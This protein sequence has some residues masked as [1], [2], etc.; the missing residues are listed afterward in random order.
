MTNFNYPQKINIHGEEWE[1]VKN[2]NDP[3][4]S[5]PFDRVNTI[6]FDCSEIKQGL[7]RVLV[8]GNIYPAQGSLEK[9]LK[10]TFIGFSPTPIYQKFLMRD[11]LRRMSIYKSD[12][13]DFAKEFTN[14]FL[15]KASENKSDYDIK[16]Y[17][18]MKGQENGRREQDDE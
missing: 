16:P 1:L 14:G 11:H 17:P 6:D 4:V 3:S 13:S 5:F 18:E 9:P 8:T 7:Y 2:A 15:G 10:L 12:I